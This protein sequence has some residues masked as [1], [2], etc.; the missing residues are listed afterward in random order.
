MEMT[1]EENHDGERCFACG[2]D[3][4]GGLHLRFG[5]EDGRVV[6]RVAAASLWVGWRGLVHGGILASMM[7]EAMGWAVA[8]DGWTALTAR[9]SARFLA[10]V[11][12]ETMLVVQAWVVHWHRRL[13]EAAAEIRTES[14]RLVARAEGTMWLVRELPAVVKD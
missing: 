6:A 3:N 10:P 11:G 8:R 14:G 1:P 9:L 12:P 7:D 4:P 5:L 13:A 2:T